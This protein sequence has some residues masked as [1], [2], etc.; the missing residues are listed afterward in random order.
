MELRLKELEMLTQEAKENMAILR[1]QVDEI[2]ELS[3]TS[4]STFSAPL[5]PRPPVV[6]RPAPVLPPK[7]KVVRAK[8]GR[9]RA[10][11]FTREVCAQIPVW[12][13]DGL[14]RVEIAAKIGCTVNSLQASCSNRG[15]SLWAKDR[16]NKRKVQVVYEEVV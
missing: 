13:E 8:V 9:R 3:I 12:L 4:T 16:P 6:C 5:T 15:I 2:V 11:L 1:K 7:I 14:N 10:I